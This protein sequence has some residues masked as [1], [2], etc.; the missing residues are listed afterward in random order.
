MKMHC[1]ESQLRGTGQ[2][3][4]GRLPC[5]DSEQCI[6]KFCPFC[7]ARGIIGQVNLKVKSPASYRLCVASNRRE[8]LPTA[9]HRL[10]QRNCY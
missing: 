10:C 9:P 8:A 4:R 6:R 7:F 3:S 1:S 5:Q 2:V